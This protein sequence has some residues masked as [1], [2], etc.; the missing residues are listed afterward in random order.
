MRQ[1]VK[2]VVQEMLSEKLCFIKH[3]VVP[4]GDKKSIDL[5]LNLVFLNFDNNNNK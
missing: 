5:K 3:D 4:K 2:T 1:Q